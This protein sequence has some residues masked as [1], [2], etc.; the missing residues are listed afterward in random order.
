MQAAMARA[1][2]GSAAARQPV[3]AR[4][5]AVL[6]TV[7]LMAV[8]RIAEAS[9]RLD[10]VRAQPLERD[11]EILAELMMYWR[12][13]ASG[14]APG[15]ARHLDRLVDL[16]EG[17]DGAAAAPA[18]HW[19]RST[20]H[21]MF[22]GRPGVRAPM[23]RFVGAA[24]QA[25]GEHHAPLRAA[26]NALRA[27]LLLW[28]GR[29]DEAQGV[30]DEV[31]GDE[32]W[33]GQPRSLRIPILAFDA[34]WHM[35]RGGR[36]A[37]REAAWAMV[38]DVDHDPARRAAWRGIYLYNLGRLSEAV[39]DRRGLQEAIDQLAATPPEAE[40][41]YMRGAR[42]AVRG[43]AALADGR[44]D[45][46]QASLESALVDSAEVDTLSV[47]ATTRMGLARVH[48]RRGDAARAWGVFA[49][50]LRRSR[51][52]G[53][54][55][56]VLLTGRAAC[57]ELADAEPPDGHLDDRDWLRR[58]LDLGLP[59]AAVQEPASPA[60]DDAPLSDRELD[61]LARST[62]ART[63]SSGTWPTSLPSSRWSRA[64]R[65]PPG[66]AT[67]CTARS[68]EARW[69]SASLRNPPPCATRWTA[70]PRPPSSTPSS[71]A[72][73]RRRWP[74]GAALRRSAVPGSAGCSTRCWRAARRW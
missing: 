60:Q 9:Q 43:L 35:L 27:W 22:I 11:T 41:P 38:D 25:A 74:C 65:P 4:Q 67:S 39:G 46:A 55:V 72:R 53:E 12:T 3:P 63:P 70:K 57:A 28:Q 50:V 62:S 49:P 42:L 30:M 19:Y 16:L 10:E 26:A 56:G 61:V 33:L 64:A 58:Q 21:F 68:A 40:W 8:G 2:A 59:S 69:T 1:A 31:R 36:E 20:P 44:L 7:G 51:E 73:L 18:A 24:L 71:P 5:A 14:P 47:D 32:R 45:E 17:R 13:G 15:P 48:L 37:M 66:T 29:L 54:P 34:A 23:E 52:A 6:E